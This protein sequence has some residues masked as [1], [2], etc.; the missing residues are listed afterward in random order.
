MKPPQSAGVCNG[1]A[2]AA[3]ALLACAFAPIGLWPLAILCPA[4]LMW[5]WDGS[6]A[7]R[8]AW[9]G[10]CF[11][12]GTFGVGTWWLYI[13]VHGFGGAPLWLTLV[14]V[15]ALVGI[16]AAYHALTGYLAVRTLPAGGAVRY[17][18][19]LPALW[20]L[21]EWWRGWF[22]SGFP[23]LALGLSQTDTVLRGFAPICGPCPGP[24]TSHSSCAA[25]RAPIFSSA[26]AIPPP[27]TTPLMTSTTRR[28]RR[29]RRIRTSV[30]ATP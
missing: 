14:I 3:G 9:S 19:G 13:S 25:C 22:L 30:F 29:S 7:R 2:L 5:L 23:W 18:L 12:A 1:L 28:S 20:L 24:R 16:M 6:T 4:V 8:A 27:V 17:L 26:T 21:L 15:M 10:F 11:G